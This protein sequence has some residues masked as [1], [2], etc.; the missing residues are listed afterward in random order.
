MAYRAKWGYGSG[1]GASVFGAEFVATEEAVRKNTHVIMHT[2]KRYILS[3]DQYLQLRPAL[4]LGEGQRMETDG[5]LT[6]RDMELLRSDRLAAGHHVI[7]R[8]GDAHGDYTVSD[9]AGLSP[10]TWRFRDSPSADIQSK[11]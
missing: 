7:R 11:L 8:K 3:A 10:L 4:L 2:G 1:A 6:V 5:D 9:G